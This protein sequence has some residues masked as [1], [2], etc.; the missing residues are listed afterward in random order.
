MF[1]RSPQNFQTDPPIAPG[2]SRKSSAGNQ[3]AGNNQPP[4]TSAGADANSAREARETRLS[5]AYHLVERV[6]SRL[7]DTVRQVASLPGGGGRVGL[8]L[9]VSPSLVGPVDPSFRALSEFNVR[10][11]KFNKHSLSFKVV[12]PALLKM[13]GGWAPDRSPAASRAGTSIV[14]DALIKGKDH[15]AL[16]HILFQVLDKIKNVFS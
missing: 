8:L 7:A 4:E 11:H 15:H 9:K 14:L 10:H 3:K 2:P 6:A 13:V 16:V 5:N 1:P 12:D